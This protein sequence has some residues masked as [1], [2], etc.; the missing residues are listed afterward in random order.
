MSEKIVVRSEKERNRGLDGLVQL[1]A[2]S[3]ANSLHSD[4]G[5]PGSFNPS[6]FDRAQLQRVRFCRLEGVSGR[7]P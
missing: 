5:E 1:A 2:V 4:E 3:P 7:A 6:A